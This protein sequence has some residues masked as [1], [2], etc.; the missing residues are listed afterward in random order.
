MRA[1]NYDISSTFHGS[2]VAGIAAGSDRTTPYYGVAPES[3]LVFVSFGSS[4][5]NITDGIQY[6]FDYAES[7][8]KPC[9]VNISLGSHLGPHDGTSASDQ[10]FAAMAGPGRIIVGAAG[11]EGSTALHV[12]KDLEEG[13]TSLKT[14]IGFSENSASKQAY[15]DIWGSKGAPLKVKAVVVDA[16]KGKVMYES[17]VTPCSLSCSF[18]E[19]FLVRGRGRVVHAPFYPLNGMLCNRLWRIAAA[20]LSDNESMLTAD[21]LVR[22]KGPY[23]GALRAIVIWTIF[24][25]L[26]RCLVML[27]RDAGRAAACVTVCAVTCPALHPACHRWTCGVTCGATY[28]SSRSAC[29]PFRPCDCQAPSS[30]FPRPPAAPC[31][32]CC[33]YRRR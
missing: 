27:F 21:S 33:R 1:V 15:V 8:G 23:S 29:R 4:N 26:R 5:V 14:M 32:C 12:G 2:H 25:R 28:A 19:N 30:P 31:V 10:A 18:V 17:P 3:E 9:V 20:F 11:N 13:D 24:L 7:V 22:R 16:L 6:C